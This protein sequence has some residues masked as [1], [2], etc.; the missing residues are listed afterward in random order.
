MSKRSVFTTITPLPD[1]VGRQVVLSTLR[2]H[3]EMIDLNPLVI[4]RKKLERP[5]SYADAEEFHAIWY[6]ITD[7]VTYL[8]VPGAKGKVTYTGCFNDLPNGLQTH[9]LAPLGVD[10]RSRW[11]LGGNLPGEPAEAVEIGL[12]I[13]RQGLYLREDVDLRCNI[14]FSS[15]VKKTLKGA[16]AQLKARLVEKSKIRQV[17]I[18][19]ASLAESYQRSQTI[20]YD[21]SPSLASVKPSSASQ[22]QEY[23]PSMYS[24]GISTAQSGRLSPGNQFAPPAQQQQRVS[25]EGYGNNLTPQPLYPVQG[26]QHPHHSQAPPPG[27]YQGVQPDVAYQYQQYKPGYAVP[28]PP[29]PIDT[30]NTSGGFAE[31][32]HNTGKDPKD[33]ISELPA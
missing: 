5:P 30:K 32:G 11:T 33:Q 28:T 29:R 27:V 23:S 21:N 19:N 26:M 14:I 2:N 17:D 20:S 18:S 6:E 8:P 12:G 24:P 13:P 25:G 7:R 16:H 9:V 10:I 31:V 15:F 4:A 1:H 3:F 22:Q